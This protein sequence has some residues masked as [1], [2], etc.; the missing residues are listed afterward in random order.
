MVRTGLFLCERREPGLYHDFLISAG[1]SVCLE[2]NLFKETAGDLVDTT[3]VPWPLCRAE[4]PLMAVAEKILNERIA[5]DP[6]VVAFALIRE[7]LRVCLIYAPERYQSFA[8]NVGN[9]IAEE[10]QRVEDG[11][12]R[13]LPKNHAWRRWQLQMLPWTFN[14]RAAD[15]PAAT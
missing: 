12:R 13:Y 4:A 7:G 3:K 9:L 15:L 1:L 14:V 8:V 11:P 10:A 2:H 5:K 6:R